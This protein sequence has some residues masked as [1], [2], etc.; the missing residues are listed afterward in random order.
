MANPNPNPEIFIGK[1]PYRSSTFPAELANQ[2]LPI[3]DDNDKIPLDRLLR[4]HMIQNEQTSQTGFWSYQ[5]LRHIMS[6]NRVLDQLKNYSGLKD[7]ETYV[8]HIR[9]Y[10]DPPEGSA[11]RTYLRIF[12]IL[13]LIEKGEEIGVFVKE[14]ISDQSLPVSCDNENKEMAYF[15][16][17]DIPHHLID[18]FMK[19][20]V[21]ERESFESRQWQLLVPYFDLDTE[22]RA[23]H[24]P[25][26][27]KTI[28]P[29]CKRDES[30][31]SSSAPSQNDGAY[32]SVSCVKI[33]PT[34][35]GFHQVLKDVSL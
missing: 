11:T 31:L 23:R 28:L 21:H 25:L 17:K 35:H 20:K 19:W 10:L 34:S 6:R 9:P 32:A 24:Y 18:C 33:E 29:W 13:V 7:A 27:D 3:I 12:A 8:D 14:Q 30:S 1:Q 15:R 26:P 4:K 5:L 16:H 2:G 22:N